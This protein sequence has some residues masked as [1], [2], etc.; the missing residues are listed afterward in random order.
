M[1]TSSLCSRLRPTFREA[2]G[3]YGCFLSKLEAVPDPP[4]PPD[5]QWTLN[6]NGVNSCIEVPPWQPA[7]AYEIEFDMYSLPFQSWNYLY[8]TKNPNRNFV[9]IDG[10]SNTFRFSSA[11]CSVFIDDVQVQ[12]RKF[13][14]SGFHHVKIVGVKAGVGGMVRLGARSSDLSTPQSFKG[15]LSNIKLTDL[16]NPANS[17]VYP[18][19]IR[20]ETEPDSTVVVDELGG[21]HGTAINFGGPG[22]AYS[23][24]MGAQE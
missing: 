13:N 1:M 14:P 20:S 10:A 6:H 2:F 18:C 9:V 22:Q 11:W 23:P 19:I 15:Q 17:R 24:L 5:Q 3:H 21:Q 7:G 4:D 8:D 12:D 16:D